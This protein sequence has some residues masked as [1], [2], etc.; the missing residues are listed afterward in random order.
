VP[1]S[2]CSAGVPPAA[3]DL[4]LTHSLAGRFSWA[5]FSHAFSDVPTQRQSRNPAFSGFSKI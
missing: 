1:F 5:L 4:P 3:F 2:E